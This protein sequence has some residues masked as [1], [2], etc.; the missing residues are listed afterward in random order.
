MTIPTTYLIS[1]SSRLLRRS[2][3][4]RVRTLGVTGPQARL[5]LVLSVS[6][7]ENQGYYAERLDVEPITLCRMVDRMEEAGMLERRHDP[8]DRR[9]WQLHLTDRSRPLIEALRDCVEQLDADMQ[10]GL[11]PAERNA[12]ADA[13]ERVRM[14]LGGNPA[15]AYRTSANG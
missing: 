6:E 15:P 11:N 7:G 13:L 4:N 5:L 12:L 9:A 14:N 8:A 2:F 3:D 1:D 10:A